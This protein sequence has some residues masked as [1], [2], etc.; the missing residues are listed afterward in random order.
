MHGTP[1]ND[2][3]S[4]SSTVCKS[5]SKKILLALLKIKH[6]V[7]GHFIPYLSIVD[8]KG[9][10]C[11]QVQLKRVANPRQNGGVITVLGVGSQGIIR[12]LGDEQKN[13]EALL[14]M[15]MKHLVDAR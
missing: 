1:G 4:S 7:L 11:V 6:R 8:N 14:S 5:K 10:V 2:R 9:E 13:N 15:Y 3:L 12:C